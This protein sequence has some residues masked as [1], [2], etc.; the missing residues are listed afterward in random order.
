MKYARLTLVLF[1]IS[2]L[3]GLIVGGVYFTLKPTIAEV[4]QN[5]VNEA[6]VSIFGT[7]YKAGTGLTEEEINNENID[8]VFP[9]LNQ[10]DEQE[11]YVIKLNAPGS[12]SGTL[13]ILVGVLN[14]GTV[15]DV[16]YLNMQETSGI[17][18]RVKGENTGPKANPLFTLFG[19]EVT[20]EGGGKTDAW[21]NEQFAGYSGEKGLDTISGAT[22]SSK[23]VVNGVD[24]ALD[25]YKEQLAE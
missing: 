8:S 20:N 24:V 15:K 14:D 2:L 4:E 13:F 22:Y 5:R 11:G 25:Y 1:I 19:L 3:S 7:G 12:Y 10:Q 21:F 17:G 9:V 23:A 16:A 6:T 18:T